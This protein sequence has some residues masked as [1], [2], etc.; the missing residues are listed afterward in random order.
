MKRKNLPL[1]IMLSA[2]AITSIATY[3][4]GYELLEKLLMLL[5]TLVVFYGLGCLLVGTMNHFDKVNEDRKKA[6][7]KATEEAEN[8]SEEKEEQH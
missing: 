7:I 2:G 8:S 5:V 6:E 3:V 4:K 1:I